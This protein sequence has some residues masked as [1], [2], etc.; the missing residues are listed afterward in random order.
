MSE[1]LRFAN[2]EE[3][4]AYLRSRIEGLQNEN[5]ARQEVRTIQ[6]EIPKSE[7]ESSHVRATVEK[8]VEHSPDKQLEE[9]IQVSNEKGVM[10]A[11]AV[12]EKIKDWK[13]EDDFHDYLVSETRGGRVVRGVEKGPL[14]RAV[15]MTLFEVRLPESE[16][17][18]QRDLKTLISSMEQFYAGMISVSEKSTIGKN[19]L[20]LEVANSEGSEEAVF[21]V[22]V[23][24]EK[25]SLFEKHLRGVFPRVELIERLNDYNVFTSGSFVL[26]AKGALSGPSAYS[27]KTFEGF[28]H[29][30]LSGILNAFNKLP[31]H[32]SGAALQ[33]VFNPQGDLYNFQYQEGIKKLEKGMKAK[34]ALAERSL[35]GE[36][37]HE[38][39]SLFKSSS[40]KE[41]KVD[42]EA[43][44]RVKKKLE[45]PTVAVNLRVIASA[46]SREEAQSI[47]QSLES[48][49]NQFEIP[50]IQKI[51]WKEEKDAEFF[52]A[53]TFRLYTEDVLP[54]N[55]RELTSLIH[56]HTTLAAT[57]TLKTKRVSE[58]ASP[59]EME[60]RGIILGVNTFQG[61]E[62]KIYFAPEDRLRHFY[63]VGQ[64]GTGKTTLLKNMVIEDMQAGEGVCFIDPHGSDI[65]DI[66]G[67]VPEHRKEDVIYFDPA[68]TA[69][70]MA[71]NML[72]YDSR[73]PEQKTFVV[74]E[75]LGI[76]NKLFDM[77]TAGGPVF[78]QYFRNAVLLTIDDPESGSTL[79]DVSRVLSNKEYRQKKIEKCRNP[80]VI[81]FWKEVAEKAGGEAALQN[82]VPYVV[83]KFDN[84][85]ANDIMRP[86]VAQE[87]SSFNFRE[88][89]DSKKI[90]LVNLSKGRLGELNANLIGLI[91]VGK[92][93]MA[94]LSR[95]DSP[96][97]NFPPFYLYI[98]EFQNITTDSLISILSEARKYKLSLTVAH[99]FLS[100]IDEEIRSAVFGNVGSLAAFRLGR[101]DSEVMEKQF[102]PVFKA[103]DLQNL[104]NFNAFVKLLV[105]GIPQ[106]AF[107][108]RL[109]KPEPAQRDTVDPLKELSYLK[110]GRNREEVE[111]EIL[112]KYQK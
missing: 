30:P 11:L 101:E 26:G 87:R 41:E 13:H 7:V 68:Y 19:Y 62:K 29:D 9:M 85:L 98:D 80:L 15:N 78:E 51:V 38:F 109:L 75:M 82:V 67:R 100:Q 10:H 111:K 1:V 79:L 74:N 4:L 66:L 48:A 14:Y 64:T 22:S 34:E 88:V 89:M 97:A 81:Q 95:A 6:R 31:K 12:V 106:K 18:S 21:F 5:E 94:A 90:L 58:A 35:T 77:K 72:E 63:V 3:E 73:Y 102:A 112:D 20:V 36:V 107:N 84:F 96:G 43:V 104:E 69:R 61:S 103:E 83:S 93:L 52:R 57:G 56:F 39:F 108:L 76:F 44:D 53:F 46:P 60:D 45:S 37:T 17:G 42:A 50:Q 2:R 59:K 47:L 110:Y 91:L 55:L 28:D 86:V 25:R 49:F 8:I 32:G 92:I 27:L 23:P 24:N 105:H 65:E 40:K 99:Q 70:P 71:L 33:I 54:L 16:E